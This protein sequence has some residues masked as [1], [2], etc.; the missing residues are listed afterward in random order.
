VVCFE[1]K[2]VVNPAAIVCYACSLMSYSAGHF[3][4]NDK[5][6]LLE[7]VKTMLAVATKLD[8]C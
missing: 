6:R 1:G 8:Q 3:L 4:E 5:E 2:T 7:G